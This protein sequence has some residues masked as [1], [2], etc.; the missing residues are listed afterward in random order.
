M[1]YRVKYYKKKNLADTRKVTVRVSGS[2][3]YYRFSFT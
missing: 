1:L 2:S 3:K